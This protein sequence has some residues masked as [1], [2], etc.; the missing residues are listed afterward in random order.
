MNSANNYL[1]VFFFKFYLF[2]KIKMKE[3]LFGIKNTVG[4]PSMIGLKVCQIKKKKK[5]FIPFQCGFWIK[6]LFSLSFPDD[7]PLM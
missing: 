7:I 5:I 1:K 4:L 3:V 2:S 6:Y